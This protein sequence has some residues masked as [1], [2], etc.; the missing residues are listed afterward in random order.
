MGAA[1]RIPPPLTPVGRHQVFNGRSWGVRVNVA[2]TL[3]RAGTVRGLFARIG[4]KQP[5]L[6]RWRHGLPFSIMGKEN[7]GT[8]SLSGALAEAM[9]LA[10]ENA[11]IKKFVK[12]K[13][14]HH[15]S[16]RDQELRR[17]RVNT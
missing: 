7:I 14:S 3:E 9:G 15:M 12:S 2:R 1:E 17:T 11:M 8:E 16:S 5:D 4:A 6:A 10:A 13:K